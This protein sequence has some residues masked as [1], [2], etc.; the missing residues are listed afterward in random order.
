M[1]RVKNMLHPY[2]TYIIHAQHIASFPGSPSKEVREGEPHMIIIK[3]A[4]QHRAVQG[5]IIELFGGS[6]AESST[7]E[8]FLPYL[9]FTRTFSYQIVPT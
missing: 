4:L 2:Y 9:L 7:Q 6:G 8:D 1:R 3:N 5:R